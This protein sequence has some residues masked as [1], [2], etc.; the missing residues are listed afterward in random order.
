MI[1]IDGAFTK[2]AAVECAKLGAEVYV[3]GV[4]TVFRQAEPLPEACRLFEKMLCD[5]VGQQTVNG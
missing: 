4:F 2:P 3:S 5:A 1:S